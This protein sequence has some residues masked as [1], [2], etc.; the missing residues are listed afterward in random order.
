MEEFTI[1]DAKKTDIPE[2]ISLFSKAYKN[3]YISHGEIQL[4]IA[5]SET[6][7]NPDSLTI[8]KKE[9]ET[10]FDSSEAFVRVIHSDS[11]H[12]PEHDPENNSE[13]TLAGVVISN[14]VSQ[15]PWSKKYGVISDIVIDS[16]F[17]HMGLGQKLV[18]DA[19]NLLKTYS[20]KDI[21][22]EISNK[23]TISKAFF[24]KLGYKAVSITAHKQLDNQ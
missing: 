3:N 9:L 1:R 20:I 18:K 8:K 4:G 14:I 15:Y 5:D 17:R 16:N 23:N 24:S 2:I 6:I 19:E 11:E 7:L 13:N 21:F 22:I 12:D 10:L